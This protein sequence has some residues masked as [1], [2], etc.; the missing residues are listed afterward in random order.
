MSN[1]KP[2]LPDV[3]VRLL[4]DG[5]YRARYRPV[6]SDNVMTSDLISLAAAFKWL[7]YV[8]SKW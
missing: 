6:G 4:S 1:K 3:S 2:G 5:Y 8:M 7:T